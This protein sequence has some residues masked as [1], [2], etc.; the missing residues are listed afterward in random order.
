MKK[1]G[2]SKKEKIKK[3][4]EIKGFFISGERKESLN[5]VIYLLKSKETKKMGIFLTKN[6]TKNI[7]KNIIRNR[8]KRLIREAYRKN[9]KNLFYGQDILFVPKKGIENLS[10]LQIEEEIISLGGVK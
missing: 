6:F 1:Y 8:I 4:K 3:N 10:Y 2:F 5:F 7:K 9:K